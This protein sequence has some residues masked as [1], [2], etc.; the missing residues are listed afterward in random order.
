MIDAS[1]SNKND[2]KLGQTYIMHICSPTQAV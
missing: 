1:V 2:L